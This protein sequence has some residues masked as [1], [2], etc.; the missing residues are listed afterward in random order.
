[1]KNK[2]E[3]ISRHCGRGPAIQGFY[4]GKTA[5]L[6]RLDPGYPAG[7]PSGMTTKRAFTLI[8]LLV[9][10]LIIGILAAVAIPQYEKAVEKARAAEAMVL[11]KAI[12]DAN[13]RYYLANG[14][15]TWSLANLDVE[16][17]GKDVTA[18]GMDRKKTNYFEYGARRSS[19]TDTSN[20]IAIANRL[21]RSTKYYLMIFSDAEGI[22]CYDYD[23]TTRK[24][25]K[26]LGAT[27]QKHPI[28]SDY[29]LL[30]I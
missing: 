7:R 21:P 11:L 13:Q 6:N 8:E 25:C 16:I 5:L 19:K 10:V 1:M 20:V 14:E 27:N 24:N 22:Y 26:A 28:Q 4:K 9:V 29:Y 2:S 3:K 23:K 30:K 15:Y 12:A 18:A 17:P